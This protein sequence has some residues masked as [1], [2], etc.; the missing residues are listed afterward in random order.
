MELNI[1]A[2][3]CRQFDINQNLKSRIKVAMLQTHISMSLRSI[4]CSSN[5]AQC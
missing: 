3:R 2:S 4:L 5:E 1:E